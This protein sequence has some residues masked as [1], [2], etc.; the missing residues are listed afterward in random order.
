MLP[1]NFYFH[2]DNDFS[3]FCTFSES[4]LAGWLEILIIIP[5][6]PN[7]S[8]GCDWAWQYKQKY[9]KTFTWSNFIGEL[10]KKSIFTE[11]LIWVHF[12][13]ELFHLL[14]IEFFGDQMV[15]EV[16]GKVQKLCSMTVFGSP[17]VAEEI[18]FS[19]S[20]YILRFNFDLFL[21]V[22]FSFYCAQMG[23]FWAWRN[24]KKNLL[25]YLYSWTTFIA[26][27]PFNTDF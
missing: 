12:I 7:W 20:T 1:T 8:W 21:G 11:K 13:F 15:F 3:L 9:L 23:Y 22:I 4:Q 18:V 6:Q 16:V 19:M 17:H 10:H 26:F 5:L 27:F 25:V 2:K 24:G 14:T